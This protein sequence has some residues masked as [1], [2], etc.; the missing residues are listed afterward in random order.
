MILNSNSIKEKAEKFRRFLSENEA[1]IAEGMVRG[2][3]LDE[4]R[5]RFD[6][7]QEDCERICARPLVSAYFWML[8][9]LCNTRECEIYAAAVDKPKPRHR[10]KPM[11][12]VV[13]QSKAAH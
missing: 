3:P 12:T 9:A 5:E 8:V 7:S 1:L 13:E 2:Q 4:M 6:V 11:L 10:G